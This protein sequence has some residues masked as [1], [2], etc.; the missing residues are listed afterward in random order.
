VDGI[1]VLDL[2]LLVLLVVVV[3][4][5]IG[6]RRVGRACRRLGR[7]PSVPRPRTGEPVSQGEALE[8]ALAARVAYGQITRGAYQQR[9]A[10]LAAAEHDGRPLTVPRL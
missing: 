5:R 3:L 6:V 1:L 10:E 2:V 7:T 4:G 9:M 8:A